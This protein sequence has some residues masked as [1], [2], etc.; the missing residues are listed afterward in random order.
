MHEIKLILIKWKQMLYYSMKEK[1]HAKTRFGDK[2]WP[3]YSNLRSMA[4]QLFNTMRAIL[5]CL[6]IF[7]FTIEGRRLKHRLH[8]LEL[9]VGHLKQENEDLRRR[10]NFLEKISAQ[11]SCKDYAKFDF[12]GSEYLYISPNSDERPYKCQFC[13]ARFKCTSS[14]KSHVIHTHTTAVV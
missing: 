4:L 3:I 12:N 11:K 5:L 14:R 1:N 7:S 10:V 8:Q 2:L 9:S 13:N 6:I